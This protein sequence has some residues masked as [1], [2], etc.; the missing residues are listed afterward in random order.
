M[1][2]STE[3]DVGG[4]GSGLLMFTVSAGHYLRPLVN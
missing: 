1:V 2:V 4:V 3:S